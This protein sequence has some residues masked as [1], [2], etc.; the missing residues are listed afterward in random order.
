MHFGKVLT[1]EGIMPLVVY[2]DTQI[3]Q[4]SFGQ[5]QNVQKFRDNDGLEAQSTIAFSA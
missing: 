1:N 3:F 4:M 2:R 5:A